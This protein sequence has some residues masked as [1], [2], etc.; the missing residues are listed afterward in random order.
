MS[1]LKVFPEF[2]I[3]EASIDLQ[4]TS[5]TGLTRHLRN[6]KRYC[7]KKFGAQSRIA[8]LVEKIPE[9][10]ALKAGKINPL[11]ELEQLKQKH[12]ASERV[13]LALTLVL[14]LVMLLM[15]QK[16]LPLLKDIDQVK[17]DLKE[18][19]QVIDM[20]KKNNEF[21]AKLQTDRQRLQDNLR[22]VYS[23]VPDNDEKSEE[24]I[25]MLESIAQSSGITLDAIGIRAVPDSQ[26]TYDDLAGLVQPYEYTFTAESDLGNILQLID[27]LR[28]SL[29][30]MD[31][32][33]LDIQQ[34]K[35]A[36]KADFSLY[37]YNLVKS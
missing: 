23:A 32:M 31:V 35:D 12:S 24:M 5:A 34:T 10:A 9:P 11:D 21:L 19:Q 7:A 16:G 15:W 30:L 17:N 8:K 29:R 25:A 2:D 18:Q 14:I 20:E 28:K 13:N 27:G 36:Y 3:P 33:T 37:A 1:E 6:F 4:P 22:K 26:F